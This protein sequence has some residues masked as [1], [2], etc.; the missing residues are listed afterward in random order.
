MFNLVQKPKPGQC[1]ARRC[2]GASVGDD[3]NPHG[4]CTRHRD[5]WL[6]AGQPDLGASPSA[7][8]TVAGGTADLRTEVVQPIEVEA[9]ALR[10]K[11]PSLQVASQE[12][13]DAVGAIKRHIQ[14]RL[15]E[16][17][18]Q[19]KRATSHLVKAKREIDSWFKPAT[20]AYHAAKAACD[21]AM[22]EYLAARDA[23]RKVAL[24]SGDHD[25]AMAID[26]PELPQGT[27]ARH[28][29]LWRVTDPAAVPREFLAVDAA[30]VTAVVNSQREKTAIPGIEVYED[31][32]LVTRGE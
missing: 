26:P 2:K 12:Q 10:D 16:T 20:E 9:F 15:R 5:I 21:R 32:T 30:R 22:R 1:P 27:H 17:E 4:L 6:D 11:L 25:T 14:T 19:R 28:R 23:E 8:S 18:D 24:Q 31:V 13:L 3:P 29:W 7:P